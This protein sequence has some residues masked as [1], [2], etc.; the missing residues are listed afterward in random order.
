MSL[1]KCPEAFSSED[2]VELLMKEI[3]KVKVLSTAECGFNQVHDVLS[4]VVDRAELQPCPQYFKMTKL[5]HLTS[6]EKTIKL[7]AVMPS[8]PVANCGDGVS[9][10]LKAGRIISEDMGWPI[11]SNRCASHSC[12]GTLKRIVTSKTMNVAEVVSCY[13]ALRFVIQHFKQSIKDKDILEESMKILNMTPVRLWT[14]GGTRM[15]HFLTACH[16]TY[17]NLIPVYNA[18][19]SISLKET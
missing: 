10:N 6:E 18:L 7:I 2:L 15:G 19:Y 14:W 8:I 16:K 13:E 11:S 1:T 12:D 4:G 5:E 9:T 17:K 3:A